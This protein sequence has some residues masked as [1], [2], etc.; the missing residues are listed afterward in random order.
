L[1]IDSWLFSKISN[2]SLVNVYTTRCYPNYIPTTATTPYIMYDSIGYEKNRLMENKIFTIV[3]YN[4][5][6]NNVE[7]M[8]DA[9]YSL[10]DNST[11]Y[12]KDTS[13]NLRI[14][15][16]TIISNNV[17]NYDETNKVWSK[18]LDVSVWYFK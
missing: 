11:K 3:S 1:N 10:F 16:A 13:S 7:L 8:N 2:S 15:S 6:K 18:V 12:I 4:N 9:L 17:V 14:E 5:S